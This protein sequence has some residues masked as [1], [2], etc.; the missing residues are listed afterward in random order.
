MK[1]STDIFIPTEKEFQDA[2]YN[3]LVQDKIY[4]TIEK[5]FIIPGSKKRVDI[6]ATKDKMHFF[7][8]LKDFRKLPLN[9]IYLKLGDLFLQVK[10]YQDLLEYTTTCTNFEDNTY[11]VAFLLPVEIDLIEINDILNMFKAH[12][13]D[14][15]VEDNSIL[16]LNNKIEARMDL[17]AKLDNKV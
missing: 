16:Y 4:D 3:K 12:K 17:L 5:E 11:I 2:L 1:I 9:A 8:E 7:Y 10:M 6:Y 15:L 14:I 13:I